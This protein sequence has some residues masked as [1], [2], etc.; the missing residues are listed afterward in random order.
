MFRS[1]KIPSSLLVLALSCSSASPVGEGGA[2]AGAGGSGALPSAGAAG[3]GGATGGK[4]GASGANTAITGGVSAGMGSATSGAGTATGGLPAAGSFSGGAGGLTTTAGG[5]TGLSGAGGKV[6]TSAGGTGAGGRGEVSG[7]SSAL[8]G[9]RPSMGGTAGTL[10]GSSVGGAMGGSAAGGAPATGSA[11]S[12]DGTTA[13]YDVVATQSGS[14]WTVSQGSRQV[15]SGSDFQQVLTRAYASLSSGRTTKQSILIQGSG[16]I[17]A[18]AQVAIPSY[19]RL[20]VC[21]TVNVTGTA[22]GSDRSPFYARNARDIEISNLKMTG[23]PQY[24]IF[25]RQTNNVI[26]GHIELRLSSSAGIGV[27]VDSGPS[28]QSQTTFNENLT[29]DYVY[30]S[31]MGSHVVETYGISNIRIGTIE[32]SA[33]GECGLLLNR[34]IHAEIG[35]VSCSDC[36]TGTGYAAFRVANSVGKVGNDFPS[37]DIH[38]GK[39]YARGGGRGIF[40]VSGSGGLTID[41]ID[42]ANTGST[43]ILLQNAYNTIIAA[44]AGTVSK[45]LVQLSNDTDNTNE[46]VY[47]PSKNVKLQN[48]VLSNG[49]SVRQDWC[50]QFG[51]NGCSAANITGGTVSMCQ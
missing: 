35:L 33:V 21:G 22:S 30:G 25:F 49:A 8:S 41:E 2:T 37:G 15:Y 50:A 40:S 51:S 17:P 7:G 31:G 10:G 34:S 14:T 26:L 11:Y 23:A 24:G 16:D 45:G 4:A 29:I 18:S 43:P 38:V 47:P 44:K 48:L 42:I 12:C 46:G 19:T 1:S 6:A 9:G 5:L 32:G 13:G 27:R 36:A 39:V 28:A 3:V 20:N